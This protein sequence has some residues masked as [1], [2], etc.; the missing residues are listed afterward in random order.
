VALGHEARQQAE[1]RGR[2]GRLDV[3]EDVGGR[4][5]LAHGGRNDSGQVE[6]VD[7]EHRVDKVDERVVDE[8]RTCS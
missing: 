2:A 7:L 4:H 1:A 5:G 8:A 3:H 6:V